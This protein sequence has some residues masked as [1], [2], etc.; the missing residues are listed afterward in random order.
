MYHERVCAGV[1]T[2]RRL[3]S[4]DTRKR[5]KHSIIHRTSTLRNFKQVSTQRQN[6]D[7][8]NITKQIPA[9]VTAARH[10]SVRRRESGCPERT[11]SCTG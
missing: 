3:H 11:G 4:L 10:V 6:A 5:P 8:H 7:V 2:K 1:P 9:A